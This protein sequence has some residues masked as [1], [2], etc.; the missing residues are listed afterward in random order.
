MGLMLNRACVGLMAIGFAAGVAVSQPAKRELNPA[1]REQV[2]K[3]AP[4]VSMRNELTLGPSAPSRAAD[5]LAQWIKERDEAGAKEAAGVD[6]TVRTAQR[7]MR[8]FFAGPATG[9]AEAAIRTMDGVKA[10]ALIAGAADEPELGIAAAI[11][12]MYAEAAKNDAVASWWASYD[13]RA[14]L[15]ARRILPVIRA[16]AL[17]KATSDDSIVIRHTLLRDPDTVA[18][19][20]VNN[21]HRPL[22]NVAMYVVLESIDGQTSEHFYFRP[23]WEREDGKPAR[24]VYTLR[25]ASDWGHIGAGGTVAAKVSVFSDEIIAENVRCAIDDNIPLAADQ[26]LDRAEKQANAKAKL[27]PL[28]ETLDRVRPKLIAYPDRVAR[29]DGVRGVAKSAFD[30]RMKALDSEIVRAHG[31]V[32]RIQDLIDNANKRTDIKKLESDLKKADT[33]HKAL[34]DERAKLGRGDI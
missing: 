5:V 3:L 7:D 23:T 20:A 9:R 2:L 12:T 27:K 33:K 6:E 32:G 4:I 15:N 13:Q 22:K 30:A 10:A 28:Y 26:Y 17:G 16:T 21:S 34:V 8:S 29:L 19:Q 1:S 11:A 14:R 25:L 24:D 31:E 18:L